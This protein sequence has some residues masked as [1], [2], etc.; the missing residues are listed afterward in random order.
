MT[1]SG[2]AYDKVVLHLHDLS[3]ER[4]MEATRVGE[5]GHKLRAYLSR[6]FQEWHKQHDQHGQGNGDMEAQD[7]E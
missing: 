5:L 2:E 4:F 7:G 1:A 3:I 6:P